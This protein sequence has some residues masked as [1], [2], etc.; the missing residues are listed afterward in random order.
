MTDL[1]RIQALEAENSKLQSEI[2][3][4]HEMV[5]NL[6]KQRDGIYWE[7]ETIR[8]NMNEQLTLRTLANID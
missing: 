2:Q 4:L 1:A 5:D 6:K 7:Y 8:Y 3:K